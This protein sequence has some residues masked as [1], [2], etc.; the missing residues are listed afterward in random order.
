V[1]F[2]ARSRERLEQ[3][4]RQ[5]PQPLPQ[6]DAGSA[7]AGSSKGQGGRSH[8]LETET[9]PQALFRELMQA[10]PDG[11]VPP[12]LLQRLRDV[13]QQKLP[14]NGQGP[15]A[16]TASAPASSKTAPKRVSSPSTRD[17]ARPSRD[18]DPLYVSFEQMLLEDENL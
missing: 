12:H 16:T 7:R 6:P 11:T 18:Q 13:E 17:R 3:L 9:D 10:S 8:R 4:G 2:D 15:F 1:A 14:L 5:L